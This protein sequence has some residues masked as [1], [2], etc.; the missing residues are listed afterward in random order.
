MILTSEGGWV[1]QGSKIT[2]I[3]D[4]ND[5]VDVVDITL[6]GNSYTITTSYDA[7][8]LIDFYRMP[9][10]ERAATRKKWECFE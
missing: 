2:V 3:M 1:V 5:D 10:N 7:A 8:P 9:R 6:R 4:D